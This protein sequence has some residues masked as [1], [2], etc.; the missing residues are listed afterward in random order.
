MINTV[1]CSTTCQHSV[2]ISLYSLSYMY[3]SNTNTWKYLVLFAQHLSIFVFFKKQNG[4]GTVHIKIEALILV[5]K[6]KSTK[7]HT[8]SLDLVT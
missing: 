4:T 3:L 8:R 1:E 6:V 2:L 7:L 5:Q